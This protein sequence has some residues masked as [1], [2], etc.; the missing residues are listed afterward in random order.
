MQLTKDFST[1]EMKCPCC[2]RCVMNPG[3]MA[4]LQTLRTLWNKPIK[5][6]SGF[7]CESHNEAVGGVLDSQ[8]PKGRAADCV[9]DAA[10]RY[11][12]IKLAIE[13]GFRGVGVASRFVH[14]D[15]REGTPAFW[16][17]EH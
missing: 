13:I 14:L 2:N 6:T 11:A 16:K 7:R 1:D 10:D 15:T 4:A 8:H 12:F 17:Y 3:F 5:I 9:V